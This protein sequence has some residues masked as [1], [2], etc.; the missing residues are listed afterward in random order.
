MSVHTIFRTGK[1]ASLQRF[2][3]ASGG[4]CIRAV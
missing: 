1:S 3:N 4:C 2:I